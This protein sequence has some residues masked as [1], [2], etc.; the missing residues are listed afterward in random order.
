MCYVRQRKSGLAGAFASGGVLGK[1]G[2]NW[3]DSP[4]DE[5]RGSVEHAKPSTDTML[6]QILACAQCSVSAK[7]SQLA[8]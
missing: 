5:P 2:I 6:V 8:A 7:H 4:M 1:W 3:P